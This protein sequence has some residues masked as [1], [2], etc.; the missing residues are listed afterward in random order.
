[1]SRYYA[2]ARTSSNVQWGGGFV[3]ALNWGPLTTAGRIPADWRALWGD[4]ALLRAV[5][6]LA[7]DKPTAVRREF[8]APVLPSPPDRR[9]LS[10]ELL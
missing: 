8:P 9:D 3:S 10:E 5:H 2:L 1:M 7:A 6:R 4:P